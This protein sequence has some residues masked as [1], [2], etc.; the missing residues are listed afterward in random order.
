MHPAG[1]GE[2]LH[3]CAY[4]AGVET[5]GAVV[6]FRVGGDGE[7]G[8]AASLGAVGAALAGCAHDSMAGA[9]EE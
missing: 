7:A 6:D 4:A 9:Q 3:D 8:A 2:V 5:V 1:G